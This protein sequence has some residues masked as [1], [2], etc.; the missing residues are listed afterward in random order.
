MKEFL[1]IGGYSREPSGPYSWQHLLFV[2]LVLSVMVALAI[3][4]GKIYRKKDANQKN[5]G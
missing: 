5:K 4:I 1:G 3:I 2:G